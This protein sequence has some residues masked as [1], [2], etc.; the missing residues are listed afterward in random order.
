M[1]GGIFINYRRGGDS[2]KPVRLCDRLLEAFQ[3]EQLFMDVD[4]VP[5]GVDFVRMLEE[6]V[7]QCDVLLAVIG[8]DWIDTRDATGARR[9]DNPDDFVRVEIESALKQGKRVIPVLV[10]EARMPSRDELPEAIRP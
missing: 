5:P 3:P 7:S 4:S 2:G 1:A 9:L 6:K 8:K 10:H